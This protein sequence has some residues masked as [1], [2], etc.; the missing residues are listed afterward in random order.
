MVQSLAY[1]WEDFRPDRDETTVDQQTRYTEIHLPDGKPAEDNAARASSDR[2]TTLFDV[3]PLPGGEGIVM[4]LRTF[5]ILPELKQILKATVTLADGRTLTFQSDL[6]SVALGN[7]VAGNQ[8]ENAVIFQQVISVQIKI[9][10]QV[11]R[12]FCSIGNLI[13]QIIP[14]GRSKRAGQML[15]AAEWRIA[16]KGIESARL[17]DFGKLQCPMEWAAVGFA[18]R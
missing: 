9:G 10:D 5:G 11:R 12:T 13:H 18:E 17:K 2:N 1:L 7:R 4:R 15:S 14:I 6:T 8:A 3:E 16:A